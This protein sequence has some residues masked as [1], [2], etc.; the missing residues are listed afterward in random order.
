MTLK[1]RSIEAITLPCCAR[2]PFPCLF[3][4]WPR[5]WTIPPKKPLQNN[6]G[7]EKD[8]YQSSMT[9]VECPWLQNDTVS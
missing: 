7:R 3:Q 8:R 5:T 9:Q 6:I 4:C 1:L 2:P